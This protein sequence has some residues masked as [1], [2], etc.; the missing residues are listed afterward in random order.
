[1]STPSGEPPV[2]Q[3][4]PPSGVPI[5]TPASGAAAVV[6]VK[7]EDKP[8]RRGFGL[9]TGFTLGA[10]LISLLV[11]G[12]MSGIAVLS[13]LAL[14][15]AFTDS[16]ASTQ[17]QNLWGSPTASNTLIAVEVRGPIL[18]DSTGQPPLFS[19]GVYGYDVADQLDGLSEDDAA[20]VILELDTPGGTIYGSKAIADAVQRYRERTGNPV[21]AYVRGVSAS[22][23]MY[24][25]AG[26]DEIIVDHGTVVGSIGVI[27]G[28]FS[29]YRDVTAVDGGL[30]SG[31]VT[32]PGGITEEY[33]SRG[34]GKDLGNP[35]RDMTPEERATLDSWLDTEYSN[36]VNHVAS[37]REI[38]PQT[39]VDSYGAYLFGPAT[40]I[41]NKLADAELG[42]DDAYRRAAA[43]AEVDPDDTN[44]QAEIDSA[45]FVSMLLGTSGSSAS[46][47][48]MAPE[49]VQAGRTAIRASQLCVGEAGVLAVHGDLTAYCTE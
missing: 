49:D 47:S 35:Y 1:M 34:K 22:G 25:M 29:R 44:V 40:A 19:Q 16:A 2:N 15:A 38:D 36:F 45:S 28:P 27:M 23:G 13:T 12:V 33:L 46:G 7:V 17:R 24:A 48:A 9:G 43:L 26:A 32:A 20:G 4:P 6:P 37:N 39:I 11:F 8:F 3:L 18:G 10:G 14:S 5:G 30:L 41:E 21:V 31:G 42:R